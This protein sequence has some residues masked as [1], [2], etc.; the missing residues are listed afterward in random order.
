MIFLNFKVQDTRIHSWLSALSGTIKG[1][2]SLY[3]CDFVIQFEEISF[4]YFILKELRVEMVKILQPH[5]G[6]EC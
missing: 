4:H 5:K 2:S 3:T 6:K 1:L